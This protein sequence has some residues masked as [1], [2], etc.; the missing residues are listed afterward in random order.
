MSGIPKSYIIIPARLASTRLPN[1]LLLKET[2]KPLIQYP[3]EAAVRS[4]LAS[5]VCVACDD[6]KI[7]D[8][9]E[10]FGG[11]AVLTDPNAASGTDRIAEVAANLADV[12]II[13]NVQ[14][15]EPDLDPNSIDLLIEL[16]ASDPESQMATLATPI[17]RQ[18][19]LNDPAC[20]K[21]VFD[22]NGRALYFSRSP[23]PYPRSWSEDLLN[24][25]PPLF[26]Q[27]LGIYAYRR[28]FLLGITKVP[29]S[30]IEKTESLEQLR[31]LSEGYAIRIGVVHEKSFGID[32]PEDYRRFVESR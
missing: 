31:V 13:V 10:G 15:D 5:G 4:R 9:V 14:G 20:V 17:H 24:A 26:Y 21:V 16:L 8:A 30:D 32:T 6:Q 25:D 1:K 29:R 22:K 3:Y 27:H 12:E 18:E 2:G 23:I 7:L 28:D 19:D 11:K